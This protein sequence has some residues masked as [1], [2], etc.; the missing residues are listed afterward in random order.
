ML[1]AVLFAALLIGSTVETSFEESHPPLSP[2]AIQLAGDASLATHTDDEGNPWIFGLPVVEA[3]IVLLA[4]SHQRALP[5]GYEPPDL[6]RVGGRSVRALVLPDLAAM[7]D[8]AA[9]DGVEIAVISAYRSPA[10]QARAFETAVWQEVGRSGG[11]IDRAE[12]EARATRFV[13]PPGHS[14]H[15]LGTAID[16]SSDE[17]GY[18]VRTAFAETATG[19]WLAANAWQYGFV[20]PYPREGE[21]R[22]GYAYEPWHYRWIGRNLAA[23]LAHDNYLSDPTRVVDDYLSA[24][25][26][27]LAPAMT[28]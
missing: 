13:A 17:I 28:P 24:A 4:V 22:S 2:L 10:E 20:L 23:A 11:S 21:V 9:A 1:L 15:Q 16:F 3:H 27:L 26:E 18:G 5:D 25:E 8:A 7:I 12:A 19:R 14:Q 6:T